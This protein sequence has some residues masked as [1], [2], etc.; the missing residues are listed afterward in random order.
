MHQMETV[1]NHRE[2]ALGLLTTSGGEWGTAVEGA[3]PRISRMVVVLTQN[4]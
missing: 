4:S 2:L 1:T 3:H